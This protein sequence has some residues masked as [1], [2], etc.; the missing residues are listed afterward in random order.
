MLVCRGYLECANQSLDILMF[1]L[2]ALVK[3][4][5]KYKLGYLFFL[6]RNILRTLSRLSALGYSVVSIM[7]H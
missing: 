4:L 5:Y 7:K 6:V 1:G 3:L 2:F